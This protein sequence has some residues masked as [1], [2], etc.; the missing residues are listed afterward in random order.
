[1]RQVALPRFG[2]QCRF[3]DELSPDTTHAARRGEEVRFAD[4]MAGFLLPDL[5]VIQVR[6]NHS[7]TSSL[8]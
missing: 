6:H 5:T 3:G 1:M 4:V 2:G 8:S 7:S